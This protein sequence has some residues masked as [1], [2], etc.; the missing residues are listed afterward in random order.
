MSKKS[1]QRK[2]IVYTKHA[3]VRMIEYDISS[4]EIEAIRDTGRIVKKTKG[5]ITM[6]LGKKGRSLV[7]IFEDHPNELWLITTRRDKS[8]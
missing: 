1:I 3:R 8:I 5:N 4:D 7:A 6:Y 2:P